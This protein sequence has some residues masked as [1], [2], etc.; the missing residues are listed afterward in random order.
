M[1]IA[2]D[3]GLGIVHELELELGHGQFERVILIEL[4]A[5][6]V[7]DGREDVVAVIAVVVRLGQDQILGDL[8]QLGVDE[9]LDHGLLFL[10]FHG[11]VGGLEQRVDHVGGD[12]L[13]KA[14]E[15]LVPH[16]GIAHQRVVGQVLHG[17]GA[18][19]GVVAVDL[20]HQ[21]GGVLVLNLQNFTFDAVAVGGNLHVRRNAQRLA[22]LLD[23][24][25][26]AG[27]F[28]HHAEHVVEVAVA[29]FLDGQHRVLIEVAGILG[30]DIVDHVGFLHEKI[31]VVTG[32]MQDF[33]SL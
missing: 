27:L 21:A 1:Q 20:G 15:G 7:G 18:H 32:H 23:D 12:V 19:H 30:L 31:G 8:A 14:R 4:A 22:R 9:A 17:T 11:H 5:H 2:V 33:L 26:L 16:E 3:E 6:E 10:V 24:D 28:L 25:G 13:G 29:D